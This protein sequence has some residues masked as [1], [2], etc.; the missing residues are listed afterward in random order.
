[1]EVIY[2][3]EGRVW[4]EHFGQP[5][6]GSRCIAEIGSSPLLTLIFVRQLPRKS[7]D[8]VITEKNQL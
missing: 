6:V 7:T 2:W 3:A 5:Y 1:L 8:S 4:G